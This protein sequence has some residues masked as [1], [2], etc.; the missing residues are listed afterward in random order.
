MRLGTSCIDVSS[1]AHLEGQH[2]AACIM[3]ECIYPVASISIEEQLKIIEHEAEWQ[4]ESEVLRAILFD[5]SMD[6]SRTLMPHTMGVATPSPGKA[7]VD[8]KIVLRPANQCQQYLHNVHYSCLPPDGYS[9][10]TLPLQ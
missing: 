6:M 7:Q 10:K 3:Y 9:L 8:G 2:E 1:F 4:G 5:M